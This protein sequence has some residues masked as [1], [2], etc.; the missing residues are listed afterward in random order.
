MM[1]PEEIARLKT[2][3]PLFQSFKRVW[4]AAIVSIDG[5]DMVL[6]VTAGHTTVVHAEPGM[7]ARYAPVPGDYYVIYADGYASISPRNA[8]EDGYR[9]VEPDA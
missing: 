7:F 4:A 5:D 3:L 6:K 2:I 9:S 1:T 8:F